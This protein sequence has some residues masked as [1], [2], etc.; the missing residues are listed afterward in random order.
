MGGWVCSK[1][2]KK[3]NELWLRAGELGNATAYNNIGNSYYR[4]R[5][6]EKD[7]KK[8][9]YYSE[10]AAMGGDITARHNV[11][12]LEYNAGNMNRAMKHWMIAAGAGYDSS[13]TAIR[14]MFLDGHA[15]KDEFEKAL[16]AHKEANDEMKSEQREIAAEYYGQN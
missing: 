6:V 11:G 4:G 16:R 5:G 13:L 2:R 7:T 3:A 12:N 14:Q 8:A 1:T 10:L 15:T 9:I